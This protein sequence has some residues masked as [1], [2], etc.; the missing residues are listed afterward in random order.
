MA[1]P[2]VF[3]GHSK[4]VNVCFQVMGIHEGHKGRMWRDMAYFPFSEGHPSSVQQM[5]GVG[6]SFEKILCLEI[7]EGRHLEER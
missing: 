1:S 7:M 2:W 4:S 5:S 3:V 6:Y